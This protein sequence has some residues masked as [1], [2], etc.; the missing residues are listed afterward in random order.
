MSRLQLFSTDFGLKAGSSKDKYPFVAIVTQG[1]RVSDSLVGGTESMPGG[2]Y[3]VIIPTNLLKAKIS[4]LSGKSVFAKETL[5][6]HDDSTV[7]GEF[8]Q[9]WVEPALDPETG[10]YISVAKASGVLSAS[11]D[12]DL[13]DDIVAYAREEK[14][15]FSY[16]LTK[17]QYVLEE[18][19]GETVARLTDFEW[20]G[21]TT[22]KREAAAYRFTKLAASKV[23]QEKTTMNKEELKEV[24]TSTLNEFKKEFITPLAEGI[25]AV[26]VSAKESSDAV[27]KIRGEVKTLAASAIDLTK[28]MDGLTASGDPAP[29]EPAGGDPASKEPAANGDVM[30]VED[31]AKMMAKAVADG[32]KAAGVDG[33]PS[34]PKGKSAPAADPDA[35]VRKSQAGAEVEQLV[36]KY[37]PDDG[38]GDLE[39]DSVEGIDASIATAK[40]TIK[41]RRQLL[42]FIDVLAAR[43]RE[44]IRKNSAHG[45]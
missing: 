38:L 19:G 3:R 13:V 20:R 34:D 41:N 22:L 25:E 45:G 44:L 4:G 43:K 35:G 39:P 42:S 26:K 5:D 21:A 18:V 1:G 30:P 37:I 36:A 6:D 12:S 40:A 10:E 29:K 27:V 15:G 23:S 2:P 9:S 28:K 17:A 16:D 33:K 7:V 31:F 32:L 8:L 24:F 11:D 14:M